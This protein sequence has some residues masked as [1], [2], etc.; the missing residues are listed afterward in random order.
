MMT[1]PSATRRRTKPRQNPSWAQLAAP[2]DVGLALEDLLGGGVRRGDLAG[3]RA[4][5]AGHET[6]LT[7]EPEGRG[8]DRPPVGPDEVGGQPED[9]LH[10]G[11]EDE[12]AADP[13]TADDGPGA[14]PVDR[15]RVGGDDLG[16]GD[17]HRRDVPDDDLGADDAADE[18]ADLP[19]AGDDL[20]ARE[21]G[22]QRERAEDEEREAEQDL[23]DRVAG[24]EVE[25]RQATDDEEEDDRVGDEER[26]PHPGAPH[27][28]P[29][30]GAHD[31]L[32]VVTGHRHRRVGDVRGR[33]CR[34]RGS[35]GRGSSGWADTGVSPSR[36]GRGRRG[37]PRGPR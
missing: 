29:G 15:V 21:A 12:D 14:D 25:R 22:Q 34:R 26:A 24:G 27:H 30:E 23:G 37:G 2:Q 8:E 33:R 7:R 31:V 19:P 5:P 32:A 4:S 11:L 20:E 3:H 28:P 36:G 17:R 18:A 6:V 13:G 9:E 16:R 1:T 35:S 10:P